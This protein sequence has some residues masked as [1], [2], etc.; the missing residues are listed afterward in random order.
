[1][2]GFAYQCGNLMASFIMIL[3]TRSAGHWDYAKVMAVS[4]ATIFLLAIF[5]IAAGREKRGEEFG[6]VSQSR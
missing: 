3:E 5:T 4:A 2:P 1:M 6:V